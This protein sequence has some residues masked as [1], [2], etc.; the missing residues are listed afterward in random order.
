[1][2]KGTSIVDEIAAAIP[3]GPTSKPWWQRLN[4]D[5]KKLIK[6]ILAAWHAGSFGSRRIT[7]ARVISDHL[8]KHGI[9][10]GQQGVQAWLQRGE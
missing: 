8:S 10:I 7:A 3:D 2:A 5:Q 6:P 9:N 4:D 1:M